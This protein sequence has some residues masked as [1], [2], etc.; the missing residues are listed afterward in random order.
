MF[1]LKSFSMQGLKGSAGG[2]YGSGIATLKSSET[3]CSTVKA[4]QH[5]PWH[6]PGVSPIAYPLQS[7][8]RS[9]AT[10]MRHLGLSMNGLFLP[11]LMTSTQVLPT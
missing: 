8:N 5:Q 3:R 2:S 6:L 11:M 10:Q 4:V 7:S 9:P 1:S